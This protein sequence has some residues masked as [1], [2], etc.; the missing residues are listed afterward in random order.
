[1]TLHQR[2]LYR[3]FLAYWPLVGVFVVLAAS[4]ALV[5]CGNTKTTITSN[6]GMGAVSVSISDPPS[7][8]APDGSFSHVFISIRSVQAHISSTA[9]DSSSGWQE[10]APQL[11]NNPVQV[12]LLHLPA[13][14][15]RLDFE[16]SGG[17]FP[18]D[19]AFAGVE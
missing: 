10:L 17:G 14:A 12:D 4:L 1:M 3:A 9:S 11:V 7:C 2:N 19:P 6:P 5:N 16:P 13:G 8:A 18:A 15:T